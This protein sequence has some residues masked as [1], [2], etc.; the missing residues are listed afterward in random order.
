MSALGWIDPPNI[1]VFSWHMVTDESV[2]H[3]DP[4]SFTDTTT[5]EKFVTRS[6][7]THS[8][9]TKKNFGMSWRF[10]RILDGFNLDGNIQ[11]QNALQGKT[12][13]PYI[14][15]ISSTIRSA[16]QHVR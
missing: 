11:A 14:K 3:Q 6:S 15:D 13:E 7:Q 10:Q 2:D 9:H 12:K 1:Q 16:S 4:L 5:G 8:T